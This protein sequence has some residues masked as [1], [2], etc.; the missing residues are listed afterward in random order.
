MAKA[1]KEFTPENLRTIR[2]DL[3][4]ALAAIDKKY[5]VKLSVGKIS[6]QAD[7]FRASLDA[8][9]A[10]PEIVANPTL[11]GVSAKYIKDLQKTYGLADLFLKKITLQGRKFT[12]VGRRAS[13]IIMREIS[14]DRLIAAPIT[15]PAFAR[16]TK[17]F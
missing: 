9:I 7:N 6:Y 13:K 5:G 8:I 1:I 17:G 16:H 4:K 10:D 14:T 3:D 15:D 11:Q 2:A 12:V